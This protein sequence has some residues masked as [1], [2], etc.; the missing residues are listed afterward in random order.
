MAR[1][2]ASI[3]AGIRHAYEN[4]DQYI[5]SIAADFHVSERTVRRMAVRFG[6]KRRSERVR[7]LPQAM[8][9]EKQVAAMAAAA[10]PP[11][12]RGR[13]ICDANRVGVTPQATPCPTLPLAGG[14]SPPGDGEGVE[15]TPSA[16]AAIERRVTELLAA[17]KSQHAGRDARDGGIASQR[18]A[19]ILASLTRIL[20]M[21]A[22]MRAGRMHENG[23]LTDDDMPLDLDEFRLD[24]A[25]QIEAFVA[26]RTDD[27]D[28]GGTETAAEVDKV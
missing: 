25:R 14:G 12:A 27:G 21:V 9:L 4:T 7:A 17:E 20:Q 15:P 26:S 1:S 11:P 10:S 28:A 6:W 16:L 8:Q 19:N 18:S 13:P 23:S 3:I 5:A 2:T 22:R 24:L